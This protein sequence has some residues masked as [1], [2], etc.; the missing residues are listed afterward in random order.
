MRPTTLSIV[1]AGTTGLYEWFKVI[2]RPILD[3][4]SQIVRWFGVALK[5]EEFKQAEEAL[6]RG[7]E[8][9]RTLADSI[10]NLAWWANGDG[11]ITWYNRRWY[12]YTGTTPEQMEGWGWQSV[13]DP[14]MLPQVLERWKASIATGEPFEMEFPLRGADGRF[15]LFLT[16]GH[17]LKDPKGKVMRWFGTNTDVDE[18]KRTADALQQ[19][20]EHLKL[21]LREKE[22]MLKEIHHRV[23]NN[24]QVIASLVD[25]QTNALA[26]PALQG[27]FQDVRD[28]VR[29]MAL[30]HEKLYQSESLA[31]VDFADYARSLLNYIARSH[32]SSENAIALKLDLQ[33]VLLSIDTA[34]PCGLILNELVSNAFKHAFRG[35][36]KGEITAALGIGPDAQ[37]FL[38]VSD[39]GVGLPAGM[40]WQ[41]SRSLGLRLI[42]LLAGQLG[43]SV[44][45]H[46]NGGAKFEITFQSKPEERK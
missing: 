6:R 8:Q 16:R 42:R 25:L 37:V 10:P 29:S 4:A 1:C 45:V 34:V 24:L 23:K 26:D 19:S 9:F 17:P 3:G 35:R 28:R 11:Y 33:P 15:R 14:E 18:L 22:V 32:G 39:N 40:D 44:S 30:V 31:Q 5:I 20:Q 2:G 46:G 38:R 12:E 41:Q 21:S 36:A 27:I 43:A 13:H 7:E